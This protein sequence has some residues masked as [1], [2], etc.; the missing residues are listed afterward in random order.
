MYNQNSNSDDPVYNFTWHTES[1]STE[2][3]AVALEFFLLNLS[4]NDSGKLQ[5][6]WN[7]NTLK[8]PPL[9]IPRQNALNRLETFFFN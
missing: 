5:F 1:H 3:S 7:W 9:S 4:L 6:R 2:I 8:F